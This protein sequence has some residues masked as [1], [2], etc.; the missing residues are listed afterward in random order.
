[1]PDSKE[2]RADIR[3]VAI[4]AHVD[5]GKTTLVDAL[6]RQSGPFR[7]HQE[8]SST[9]SW[10]QRPGARA[11]HH[12]PGQE[13]RRPLRRARKINI[14]DTPGHADFGGEVERIL[15]MADGVLLLVDAAEGPLPQTRFVLR[16]AL[17][18]RPQADRRHQQD[19]PPRRPARRGAQRGL[20]PVHRPRRRRASSSTSR[21]STPRPRRHRDA[22]PGDAGRD[23]RSR[24]STDPRAHPGA[25]V[26]AGRAAPDAQVTNLDCSRLR[27]PDRASAGSA[28]ARSRDGPAVAWCR[29]DGTVTAHRDVTELIVFDG[30]GRVEAEQRRAGRHRRRRRARGRRHRRHDRRPGRPAAAAADRRRRADADDDLHDQRLALRRPRGQ[31]RHRAP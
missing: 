26:D 17:A 5:H 31:V 21:S 8:R 27:R 24:S 29:A 10:T 25:G 11:R 6:L 9:A 16:K 1:M 3:N 22:R 13:H 15:K 20:R 2:T 30:L 23:D 7:A 12:D 28:T 19:R 18:A 4:I 14:I